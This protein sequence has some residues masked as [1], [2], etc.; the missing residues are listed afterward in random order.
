MEEKH[1]NGS[2]WVKPNPS[3]EVNVCGWFWVGERLRPEAEIA[4]CACIKQRRQ[5]MSWPSGDEIRGG[6]WRR[7]DDEGG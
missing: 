2:R 5:S 6:E 4:I 1:L 3:G 7:S